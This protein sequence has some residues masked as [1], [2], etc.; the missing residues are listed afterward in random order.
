MC[1]DDCA[2][3]PVG[4]FRQKRA[5]AVTREDPEITEANRMLEFVQW[6]SACLLLI[7]VFLLAFVAHKVR[8]IHQA[9]F[10]LR[11][12]T[13]SIRQEVFSLFSQIQSLMALDR[14][15]GLP[16][17]L[18][19]MRGWVGSPDFLLQVADEIAVT[20]PR[21]VMECSSGVSTLVIARSLQLQGG[22]HVY[23]LEHEPAYAQQT[24][25]M[26]ARFGLAE[27]A[28]VLDAPLEN[29]HTV[30]PWYSESVIPADMPP[31]ELLVIDGPPASALPLARYPALPRLFDRLAPSFTVMLD[32]ADRP[33][34]VEI[35]R[36]WCTQWPG[37]QL[38]RLPAEKGL[39]C[40]RMKSGVTP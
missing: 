21:C 27:W 24:R 11:A 1:G 3:V 18:P 7:V 26:L 9:S 39:A 10:V 28:T 32:D 35:V 16:Q 37:L 4:E 5:A 30:T 38:T 25:D 13:E 36:R 2:Q 12:D 29:R 8:R 22:G 20:G 33:G 17:A 14:K 23:S 15:L 19:A 34:E 6:L 40:L 31:V